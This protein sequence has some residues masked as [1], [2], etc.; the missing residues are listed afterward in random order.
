MIEQSLERSIYPLG[1]SA[2]AEKGP[3]VVAQVRDLS[4]SYQNGRE[5]SVVLKDISLKLYDRDFVCLLGPSGCG[6]TTLLN[7]LAGYATEYLGSILIDGQPHLGPTP[8]VG[9]VFQS[10]NLF[11]WLTAAK[12]IEF[13]LKMLGLEK[14]ARREKVQK[15]LEIISLENAADLL[16][17]QMSGG[18]RQRVA[19]A[20]ALA[21]DSKIIL[22][23]EPFS[24]LDALTREMMQGHLRDI[25]TKA[26]RC[27]F[28]I[29]HDVQE[30][31]LLA[32]RLIVMSAWPGR[33]FSDFENPLRKESGPG[34]RA[35]F[36]SLRNDPL[37]SKLRADL[38]EMIQ[39]NSC[40]I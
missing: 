1:A 36:D 9:V 21:L 38:L 39:G 3:A 25:W 14:K 37:F 40:V 34:P 19:I 26:G 30:A 15:L 6:K 7:L 17:H 24:A 8:R 12:N 20:R 28:F 2:A 22:L 32:N 10:P 31:L 5:T 4:L 33:I 18:M 27:F 11:P 29:T 13:G 23:D 16:P 35:D